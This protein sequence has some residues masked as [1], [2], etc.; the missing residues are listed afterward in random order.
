MQDLFHPGKTLIILPDFLI[1]KK[2]KNHEKHNQ[3]TFSAYHKNFT[4]LKH[5]CT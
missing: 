1:V 4:A 5:I 3:Q 2:K